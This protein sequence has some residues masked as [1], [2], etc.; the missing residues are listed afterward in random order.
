MRCLGGADD[1]RGHASL[2]EHPGEG[3]LRRRDVAAARELCDAGD[4]L[5]GSPRAPELLLRRVDARPR[6]EWLAALTA[7]AREEA[8]GERAVR[9]DGEAFVKAE[10]DH[11]AFLFPVQE[12][13]AVLH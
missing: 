10:R 9:N 6:R 2:L 13:V 7:A 5:G 8:A 11:L 12:A 1:R 4:D 3:D